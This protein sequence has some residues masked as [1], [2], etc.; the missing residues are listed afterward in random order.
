[1]PEDN[2]LDRRE[3]TLESF[4]TEDPTVLVVGGGQ[5]GLSLAARL[6]AVGMRTL[7]VDKN[8]RVGDCWRL[9]CVTISQLAAFRES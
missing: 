2:W 8:K 6:G 5:N 4:M 1:M 7:V 3:K 9:R